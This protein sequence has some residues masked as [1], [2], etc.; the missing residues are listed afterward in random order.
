MKAEI[1]ISI[2]YRRFVTSE[3]IEH[4]INKTADRA[5]WIPEAI[6]G[7]CKLLNWEIK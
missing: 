5:G 2:E 6:P 1:T 4:F 7:T 3:N